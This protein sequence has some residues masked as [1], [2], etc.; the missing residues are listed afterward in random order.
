M[1]GDGQESVPSRARMIGSALFVVLVI[2]SVWWWMD[3]RM[4]PPPIAP[5]PA[6]ETSR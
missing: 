4:Q 1:N 6:T 2:A 3:S 5:A